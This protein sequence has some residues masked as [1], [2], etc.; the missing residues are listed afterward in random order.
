M[1]K[2]QQNGHFHLP[3]NLFAFR[4]SQFA[5]YIIALFVIN[6]SKYNANDGFSIFGSSFPND[7]RS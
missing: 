2:R 4:I 1:P 3:Y 6:A 7:L 5:L